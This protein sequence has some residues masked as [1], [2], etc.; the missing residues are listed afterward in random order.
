MKTYQRMSTFTSKLKSAVE[1]RNRDRI[2]I[3]I[4]SIIMRRTVD[5]KHFIFDKQPFLVK[6]LLKQMETTMSRFL[7]R[8]WA[9]FGDSVRLGV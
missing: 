9:R 3:V 7:L 5:A 4:I 8:Y 1:W 6:G 2:E